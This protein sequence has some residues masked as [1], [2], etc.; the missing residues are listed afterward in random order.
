MSLDVSPSYETFEKTIRPEDRTFVNK[1]VE[2][3]LERKKP[4]NIE[5]RIILP[6]GKE[7]I[8]HA[9]GK[10]DYDKKDRPLRFSGT[11]QDIT[12]RK[13]AQKMLQRSEALLIA[14]E[15]LTKVGGWEWDVEK[16][17]MIF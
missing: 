9:I 10:V 15:Q 2:D 3:A 1:S 7:G 4:Y 13:R 14:T 5:F 11:V 16:Q 6:D 8:V 12:E 17:T